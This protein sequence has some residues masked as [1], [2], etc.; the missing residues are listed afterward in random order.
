MGLSGYFDGGEI[1]E[2][3]SRFLAIPMLCEAQNFA[4]SSS[5]RLEFVNCG[6][7]FGAASRRGEGGPGGAGI[8]AGAKP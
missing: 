6:R 7:R 4:S 8:W 5:S 1:S 3:L 2:I